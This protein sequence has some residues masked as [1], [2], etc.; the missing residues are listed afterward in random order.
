MKKR[1]FLQTALAVLVITSG[2]CWYY[3]DR[4]I[5]DH[6][7]LVSGEREQMQFSMLPH[8]TLEMKDA[9]VSL[10]NPSDIPSD[11]VRISGKEPFMMMGEK[12]GSYQ[13]EVK[14]FG[15]LKV[16]EVQ[17]DVVGENYA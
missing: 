10:G 6:L 17:V 4:N 12:E 11:Q 7:N 2:F 15:L 8:S 9:E 16:K 1:Y 3:M 5:P 13:M 14:L